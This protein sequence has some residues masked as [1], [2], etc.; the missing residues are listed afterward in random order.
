MTRD[1]KIDGSVWRGLRRTLGRLIAGPEAAVSPAVVSPAQ[2]PFEPKR[3]R[4][5]HNGVEIVFNCPNQLTYDRASSVMTKEPGTISWIES[6]E[7]NAIFWDIG[8]NVG[9]FSLYAAAMRG[10][11]VYAFEPVAHNFFVLQQNIMDNNLDHSVKA[12]SIAIDSV[13]KV[14]DL[15]MRDAVFGSA[16]HVFG[17]NVDY[18]GKHYKESHR[19]GCLGVSID[20]LCNQFG[21]TVP[22]Y[23]KIDVDGLEQEVISG[24]LSSFKNERCRS[25]L[26]ELDLNDADEVRFIK[27]NLEAL[28]FHHDETVPGNAPRPHPEAIVYN[29]IF[30]RK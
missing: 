5:A 22:T 24:G 3:Y 28:G 18:T 25:V 17:D 27:T 2:D 16:L 7:E 10:C 11:D 19:Q 8:A 23:V 20:T 6:F 26:V 12:L 30:N 15:F 1:E 13:D 9:T 29:M 4:F 21:M 14:A